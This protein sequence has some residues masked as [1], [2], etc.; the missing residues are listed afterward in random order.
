MKFMSGTRHQ[1]IEIEMQLIPKFV[2]RTS[3]IY[4]KQERCKNEAPIQSEE[5]LRQLF[6]EVELHALAQRVQTLINKSEVD[7]TLFRNL[8]HKKRFN[9]IYKSGLFPELDDSN[10]YTA[11]IF[12]LSADTFLWNRAKE[13]IT[14]NQI[15]F[16]D[17]RIGG[18]DLDGYAI[19]HMAKE[20]YSGNVH[21]TVAELSD[22]E[23]INDK[24]LR[25]MFH[26]FLVRRNGIN[27]LKGGK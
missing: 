1:A 3:G 25:L 11:A 27:I 17:I 4:I 26:S 14:S 12:L 6:K 8:T 23:V 24:L 18:V 15:Y 20:L 16:D 9:S 21:V 5:L 22:K 19:F 13:Y 10:G 2:P 7:D